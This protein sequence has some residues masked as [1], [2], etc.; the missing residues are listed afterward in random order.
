MSGQHRS[1]RAIGGTIA[2]AAGIVVLAGI[3]AVAVAWNAMRGVYSNPYGYHAAPDV[4]DTLQGERT[5]GSTLAADT[6]AYPDIDWAYWQ[7]ANPDVVAWITI[8]GTS[9]DFPVAYAP[10]SDPN[11][12]LE[13]DV[14]GTFNYF[15]CIFIDP[16]CPIGLDSRNC[17]LYGHNMKWD[18]S[19]FGPLEHYTERAFAENHRTVLVQTPRQRRA[20]SVYAVT[21]VN[22]AA[23]TK[24]TDFAGNSAFRRWWDAAYDAADLQLQA[25]P[26]STDRVLTLC[27]CSYNEWDNERTLVYAVPKE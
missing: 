14:Y 10:G 27:T 9:V 22:G 13:H 12:Y 24:H 2:L 20:Y 19:M 4:S 15:G 23:E 26:P 25:T 7:A 1:H 6:D 3:L 5:E 17:I 8:P 11:Y 18:D 21:V 16:A